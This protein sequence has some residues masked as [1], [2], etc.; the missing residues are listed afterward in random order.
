MPRTVKQVLSEQAKQAERDRAQKPAQS[1]AVAKPALPAA[2]DHR[3]ARRAIPRRGRAE[4][5]RRPA[6]QV[7]RQGRQVRLRRQREAIAESE[8][9]VVLADQTLVS[10]V[11]FQGDGE[12]PTRVGGLL[13][14]P[15][16][17]LPPREQLGDSDPRQL[18]DR[19]VGQARGPL[20]ARDHAGAAAGR[21]RWS[22]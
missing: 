21:P 18:G 14:A 1:V 12:P 10:W 15:D 11:K 16:F 2:P 6:G 13:Y 22:S 7:R 4:R 9:F 8:D 20:E 3:S 5:H 19:P 17:V